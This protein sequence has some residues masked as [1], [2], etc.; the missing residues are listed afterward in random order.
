LP[1]S[2]VKDPTVP[3]PHSESWRNNF[4]LTSSIPE[5]EEI[6]LITFLLEAISL[7]LSAVSLQKLLIASFFY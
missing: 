5:R 6:V 7:Q 1:Y 4:V 3:L 2:L